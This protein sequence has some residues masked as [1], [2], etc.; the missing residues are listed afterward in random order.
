MKKE[1][2]FFRFIAVMAF[3]AVIGFAEIAA[4]DTIVLRNGNLVRG[5]IVAQDDTTVR[6]ATIGGELRITSETISRVIR[7]PRSENSIL[8]AEMQLGRSGVLRGFQYYAS[9]RREGAEPAQIAESIA[10]NQGAILSGFGTLGEKD[11]EAVSRF[12]ESLGESG[13]D[14]YRFLAGQVLFDAGNRARAMTLFASL[15]TEFYARN[16]QRKEFVVTFFRNE[17]KSLLAR[18]KFQDA[19]NRIETLN[20]IDATLGRSCEVL[21]YLNWAAKARESGNYEEALKIY[22]D[23]LFKISPP[24]ARERLLFTLDALA[25]QSEESGEYAKAIALAE[26]YGL[27]LSPVEAKAIIV[28]LREGYARQLMERGDFAPAKEVIAQYYADM[29]NEPQT[30]L[31]ECE[32]GERS[33]KLAPDDYAGHYKLAQYCI[34]N[35]LL[36]QAEGELEKAAGANELRENV[37]KQLRLLEERKAMKEFAVAM[38]LYERGLYM[39]ALEALLHF[40]ERFPKSDMVKEAQKM[41]QLSRSR[42]ESESQ[43]RPYQAEVLFQQ[44]ERSFFSGDTREAM[45]LIGQIEE[46]YADTPAGERAAKWKTSIVRRMEIA[47]LEGSKEPQLDMNKVKASY[48]EENIEEEIA[49]ILKATGE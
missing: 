41:V 21:L 36:D 44:A 37:H 38:Q 35:G 27:R 47:K 6:L 28:T 30:L 19:I 34:E 17:I 8:E 9:A 29:P 25:R 5:I 49:K 18:E 32:Y 22:T 13:S 23:R 40:E 3:C 14:D 26:Q 12:V 2:M 33:G 42:M 10:A 15:S 46:N 31:F 48:S 1:E 24:I 11:K 4:P 45:R 16:E 39:D 43:R 20:R 7:E